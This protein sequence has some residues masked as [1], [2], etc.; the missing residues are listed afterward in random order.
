MV[1]TGR[2]LKQTLGGELFGELDTA[3]GEEGS[4]GL[5]LS[6][7]LLQVATIIGLMFWRLVQTDNMTNFSR[8]V[9]EGL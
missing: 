3:G 8:N 5:S 6:A 7:S 2:R 1:V 9:G 4:P